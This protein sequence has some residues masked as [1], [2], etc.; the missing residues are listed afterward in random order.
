MR[1]LASMNGAVFDVPDQQMEQFESIFNHAKE[2]G[3]RMDFEIEKCI[4]MPEL[5]DNDRGGYGGGYGGESNFGG[6][7]Y[8]GRGGRQQSGGYGGRGGGRDM[9]GRGGR[10]GGRSGGGQRQARGDPAAS[11][12]IG[13][14]DYHATDH[15]IKSM[16]SGAGLNAASVR[17]LNDESGRSKGSAFVD[18]S[19]PAEAATACGLNGQKLGGA[20]RPLRINSAQR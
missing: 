18:F 17:V 14:L 7:G 11:V 9:G 3:G 2:S 6:G 1:S 4:T 19:S 15:D 20:Q 5:L 8:G 13:N 12:F 16:F 10:D